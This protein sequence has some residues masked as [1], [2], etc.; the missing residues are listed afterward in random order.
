MSAATCSQET[1]DLMSF[2]SKQL[3]PETISS[4]I[5]ESLMN[6]I[7]RYI[8]IYVKREVENLIKN[9]VQQEIESIRNHINSVVVDIYEHLQK[10]VDMLKSIQI[11]LANQKLSPKIDP[12][13]AAFESR[14]YT[15]AF[16]LMMNLE[17]ESAKD[18][19][20]RAINLQELNDSNIDQK[21]AIDIA[22]WA[23]A[24]SNKELL[25]KMV[26]IIK[27]GEGL[28]LL[29]RK[30]VSKQ[31]KSLVEVKNMIIKKSL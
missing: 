21:V 5:N 4:I 15:R 31:D 12:I 22:N 20:S 10:N 25:T 29:L 28:N 13:M 16:N 8:D 3:C 11:F 26:E 2:I 14:D 17:E 30:I 6:S 18:E 1:Q 19:Y 27:K 9:I 7:S 24:R 23:I